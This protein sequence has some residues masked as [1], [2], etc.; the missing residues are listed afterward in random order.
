ME[1][2]LLLIGS[3]ELFAYW[4]LAAAVLTVFAGSRRISVAA[5]WLMLAAGIFEWARRFRDKG[6]RSAP[7]TL[8]SP[9][10]GPRPEPNL[11][12]MHWR[13]SYECGHPVIDRQHRE[14]FSMGN[15]LINDV[16]EGKSK[17]GIEYLLHQ[18]VEQ[19]KEHFA[20]EEAVLVRTH[21]PHLE[22]H[23]ALH[24]GLLERARDLEERC[25]RGVLPMSELVGFVA[26]DVI[27]AHIIHD[28]VKFALRS[29]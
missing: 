1:Y 20:S 29:R 23:R 16:L 17:V 14:L 12:L 6:K 22:Q 21:F 18:L 3:N 19:T 27:A 26:Y 10:G 25:R 5:G 9:P 8:P 2:K 24:R 28:D 4:L 15:D 11:M 7:S 13:Q